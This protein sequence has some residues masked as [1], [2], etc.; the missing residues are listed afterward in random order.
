MIP[1][2]RRS[3][4]STRFGRCPA[5][6]LIEL[7]VVIAII[8]M[9]ISILLPAL[10]S[11]REQGRKTVCLTNMRSIGMAVNQYLG[12]DEQENL[13][14]TYIYGPDQRTGQPSPWPD[15]V[16]EAFPQG[17]R[18]VSSY[19]W[20]GQ[21]ATKPYSDDAR[22]HGDFWV[23]PAEVRP[24]N[25]YL[26][27]SATGRAAIKV[28]QCPGDRSA[29]SPRVG[30][31]T[32]HDQA[33]IQDEGSRTSYEAYGNSYSINWFFMEE[34]DLTGWRLRNLFDHGKH[35]IWMNRNGSRASEWV[36]MWE[37]Q[38]DQLLDGATIS[39]G[40]RLGGG[41]HRRFSN[42]TFLFLDGHVEHHYFDTRSVWGE[43]WRVYRKWTLF[44]LPPF[45]NPPWG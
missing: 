13:P 6:T 2:V 45:Y 26:D 14:W 44:N 41:W 17:A 35:S 37:N 29:V 33:P 27:A 7:L 31:R 16:D 36:I 25:A 43:G 24:L 21:I 11:A 42:H 12:N 4:Q 34:P 20:G 8:A 23:T 38:V 22:S 19:T 15:G 3:G 9:L 5:F 40:G 32:Q 18:F 10:N 39:M 28:T 1:P 30:D